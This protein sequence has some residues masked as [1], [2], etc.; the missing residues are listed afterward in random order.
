MAEGLLRHRGGAA[1]E[2]HSAG[3]LATDVRPEAR[4]VM[5]EI[6][7]DL[8][9]QESK[10]LDRYLYQ[11]FDLVVTVC[12]QAADT[13]P[14][15]ANAAKRLHWSI[16]DPAAVRGSRTAREEAFRRAREELDRRIGEEILGG[17]NSDDR[18]G[19]QPA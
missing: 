17:E 3:S 19:G 15:F 9:G 12:D 2:A 14:T 5:A 1:F 10:T 6:G 16:A 4:A 18:L 8:A 11:P 13:C 7:I